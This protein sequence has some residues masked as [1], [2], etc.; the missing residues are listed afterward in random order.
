MMFRSTIALF[1]VLVMGVSAVATARTRGPHPHRATGQ[2]LYSSGYAR[3]VP[4]AR[5]NWGAQS[6]T[7][8]G[9]GRLVP[10]DSAN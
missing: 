4:A 1:A 7:D 10:C 5:T 3:D 8:D 2:R 6:V 9:Q